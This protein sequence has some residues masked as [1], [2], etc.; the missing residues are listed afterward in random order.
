MDKMDKNYRIQSLRGVAF[1]LVFVSH[2]TLFTN[3]TGGNLFGWTGALGVELFLILSGYLSFKTFQ[4][5]INIKEYYRKKLA[6]FFPLHWLT[7][8]LAIPLY[9]PL[10]YK[11]FLKII[12]NGFLLQSWIPSYGVYFSINPVSWYLSIMVFFVL[13]TPIA[14]RFL[15]KL[16]VFQGVLLLL[17]FEITEIVLTT[18]SSDLIVDKHWLVYIFPVVRSLDFLAGGVLYI[19]STSANKLSRTKT[20]AIGCMGRLSE[21]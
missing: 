12:I 4:G 20:K 21:N 13:I 14:N 19:V 11:D 8:L 7:L 15:K 2:C 18:F 10:S 5:V 9:F 6:R 3:K 1:L 16:S 17:L